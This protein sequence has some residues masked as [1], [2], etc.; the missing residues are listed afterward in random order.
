MQYCF[1]QRNGI[2]THLSS[3]ISDEQFQENMKSSREP[4]DQKT[5]D[6]VLALFNDLTCS[7]WE[8]TQVLEYWNEMEAKGHKQNLDTK[9]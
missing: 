8:N 4:G 1:Q 2:A 7:Q 5:L 3:M 9:K 6:T